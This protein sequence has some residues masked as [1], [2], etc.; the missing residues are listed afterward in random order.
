MEI[1]HQL[2]ARKEQIKHTFKQFLAGHWRIVI[3]LV[4]IIGMLLFFK[5]ALVLLVFIGLNA[6]VALIWMLFQNRS[7]GLEFVLFTSV[8][9]MFAYGVKPAIFLLTVSLLI[10]NYITMSMTLN[11]LLNIPIGIVCLLIGIFFIGFGIV[12][13]G[14]GLTILFNLIFTLLVLFLKTGSLARRL[15][16][17]A[18][19][20][21]FNWFLFSVLG[22]FLVKVL[23]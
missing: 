14:I 15:V 7:I 1:K 3:A 6:L 16:Y 12:K 10:H 9:T 19:N 4:I 5:K 2:H 18:T 13:V 8:V 21:A 23:G 11:S 17:F 22:P 20:L